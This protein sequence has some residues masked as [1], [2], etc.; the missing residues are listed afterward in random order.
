VEVA[1]TRSQVRRVDPKPQAA[2]FGQPM[3]VNNNFT[4]GDAVNRNTQAQVAAAA[5]R[6]IAIANRRNN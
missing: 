6:G 4:V 3:V 1:E 5:A 2:A